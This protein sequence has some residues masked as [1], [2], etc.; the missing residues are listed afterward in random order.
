MNISGLLLFFL[1]IL[2]LVYTLSAAYCTRVFFRRKGTFR[3]EDGAPWPRVSIIKPVGMTG[4]ASL[5]D[6]STFCDLDYPSY[7]ILFT[8]SEENDSALSVLE[9]L[10]RR[11]P[12]R[13][14]RWSIEPRKRGPNYKVDNLIKAVR[15]ARYDTLVISDSD[16]GVET[17]YLQQIIPLLRAHTGLVT[18][19]YRGKDLHSI[20]AGLQSLSVQTDFIPKVLLGYRLEGGSYGFG[21]TLC[22]SKEILE[23]SGGFEPLRDY[24][25]DDY[26]IGNRIQKIGYGIHIADYLV[27]HRFHTENFSVFLKHNLRWAVTQRVCRPVGYLASFVTH[28]FFLALVFLLVQRF[29]SIAVGLFLFVTGLRLTSSVYLNATVIR[30][31]EIGRYLWLIPI[32]DLLATGFWFLSLFVNTVHW[33]SHR[34]RVLRGGKM[35]EL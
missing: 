35:I 22:T 11:F 14:I 25:A 19:L 8:L 1:I 6:F 28:G 34:Y 24:L 12:H 9:Q 20:F 5:E 23:K 3:P 21:A 17:D 4:N 7:E 27:D 31:K 2:S 33:G 26:Q 15:D 16:M 32:N 29:S 10:K 18:C 30:N 13:E